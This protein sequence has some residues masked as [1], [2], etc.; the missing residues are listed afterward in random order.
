LGDLRKLAVER[1]DNLSD[2]FGSTSGRR[3]NVGASTT[4]TTP[5]LGGWSI[6]TERSRFDKLFGIEVR[7]YSRLLGS[8]RRMNRGHQALNDTKLIVDDLGK[9]R[10]AIGCARSVGDLPIEFYYSS[11]AGEA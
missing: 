8:G 4:A 10:K 2:G 11:V 1:R 5:V 3:D 9:G 7:I 6:D